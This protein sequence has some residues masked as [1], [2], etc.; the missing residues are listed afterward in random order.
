MEKQEFKVT[1]LLCKLTSEKSRHRGRG[2]RAT[3]GESDEEDGG[4]ERGPVRNE[5]PGQPAGQWEVKLLWASWSCSEDGAMGRASWR[6][7]PGLE[8]SGFLWEAT[9]SGD[10]RQ[11]NPT[12]TW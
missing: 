10:P 9:E 12:R 6:P 4:G 2:E 3:W 8:K 1:T 5:Q 11:T 7:L